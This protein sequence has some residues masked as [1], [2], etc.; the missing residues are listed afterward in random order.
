MPIPQNTM[1]KKMSRVLAVFTWRGGNLKTDRLTGWEPNTGMFKNYFESVCDTD[2]VAQLT[3]YS[4]TYLQ[5]KRFGSNEE[6][7]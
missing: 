4:V 7:F 3:T 5:I 6:T 1:K 2:V